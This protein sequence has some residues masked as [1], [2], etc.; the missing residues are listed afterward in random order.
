MIELAPEAV[1]VAGTDVAVLVGVAGIAVAVLVLVGRVCV[2]VRVGEAVTGI[3][4]AVRVAVL[5]ATFVAVA[6][7]EPPT[8]SAPQTRLPL[9]YTEI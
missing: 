6:L 7:T 3:I 4:V 5:I 1:G 2:A 9:R 8:G